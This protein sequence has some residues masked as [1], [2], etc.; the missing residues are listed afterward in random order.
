[1]IAISEALSTNVAALP[2]GACSAGSSSQRGS[3]GFALKLSAAQGLSTAPQ[4]AEGAA[5]CDGA[6]STN[7]SAAEVAGAAK[8]LSVRVTASGN[9]QIKRSNRGAASNNEP[10]IHQFA[11]VNAV[12]PESLPAAPISAPVTTAETAPSPLILLQ[13]NLLQAGSPQPAPGQL[14]FPSALNASI[15]VQTPGVSFGSVQPESPAID[16]GTATGANIPIASAT[17]TAAGS[18]RAL[19]NAEGSAAA[20]TSSSAPATSWSGISSAGISNANESKG[21]GR[22]VSARNVAAY[23]F[24][25]AGGRAPGTAL[26]HP[27][28]GTR[29]NGRQNESNSAEP[30]TLAAKALPLPL[31]SATAQPASANVSLNA[32]QDSQRNT[33]SANADELMGAELPTQDQSGEHTTPASDL[34]ANAMAEAGA[35]SELPPAVAP[36]FQIAGE[37]SLTASARDNATPTDPAVRPGT[38]LPISGSVNTQIAGT[39][40]ADIPASALLNLAEQLV[41]GK[42]SLTRASAPRLTDAVAGSTGDLARVRPGA[43]ASVMPAALSTT[44]TDSG[45]EL[46]IARQTPF[47]IFFSSTGPDAASA[48]AALPKMIIPAAASG[49]HASNADVGGVTN[50]NSQPDGSRGSN[51]QNA[52]G[53]NPKAVPPGSES[54]NLQ[55]GPTLHREADASAAGIQVASSPAA[56]APIPPP[57]PSGTPVSPVELATDSPA[58]AEAQ[59]VA[60]AASPAIPVPATPQP[61]VAAAPGPVQLAQMV[62]R[63][64]QS[65]MRIGM[66]TSAFGSVEVRT[67]VHANDVGLFIGSEKGDLR[68]LMTNEMPAL[69]NTLQQQNLRLN[70]VNFTQGFASSGNSSGGGDSQQRSFVPQHAVSGSLVRDPADDAAEAPTAS[71]LRGNRGLSIL[72]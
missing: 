46:P 4:T 16:S 19:T 38:P 8:T 25:T 41:S 43:S 40:S 56:G 13:S 3:S 63:A 39:Q 72:A 68:G 30:V 47:S 23:A 6:V 51:S 35:Q 71:E 62:S 7:G 29:W 10:A 2:A 18:F 28:E 11:A 20:L 15:P 67:V 36:S 50:L 66:S 24:S 5:G 1:M 12:L 65:E 53:Q 69:T 17:K 33:P 42:A 58:K 32:L 9:L 64:G 55:A 60:V 54:G 26:P 52:A 44:G 59:S 48:A 70:S 57:L 49:M 45:K 34:L 31:S 61:P 37:D 21:N 27:G 14:T 22:E